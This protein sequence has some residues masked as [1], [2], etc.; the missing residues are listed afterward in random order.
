LNDCPDQLISD[1]TKQERETRA[2]LA[3]YAQA[4]KYLSGIGLN[5][6]ADDIIRLADR[7]SPGVGVPCESSSSGPSTE[8]GTTA[9]SPPPPDADARR[10]TTDG[11]GRHHD[12]GLADSHASDDWTEDEDAQAQNEMTSCNAASS[13]SSSHNPFATTAAAGGPGLWP[14]QDEVSGAL[15]VL[16]YGPIYVG[17]P[18]Q[19]F[20]VDFDTGSADLWLPADC[21]NC[22]GRQ[23]DA[24]RSS[25]YRPTNQ[26]ISI[27][28]VGH[29]HLLLNPER[30]LTYFPSLS[31]PFS[32]LY[33][34]SNDSGLKGTGKVSGKVVR[35]VVSTAGLTVA[36]QAFGSVTNKSDEFNKQPNDGLIGMAFGTIAQSRQPT[37]FENLIK[38]RKLAA[39]LFSVHLSR[40]EERGSSVRVLFCV[41]V[42]PG[43]PC[44]AFFERVL[45]LVPNRCASAASIPS[46]PPVPSSGSPWYRRCVTRLTS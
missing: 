16:Y 24:G 31:T 27:T 4:E 7:Y 9:S 43:H 37:F 15:D 28:Y 5:P 34:P 19:A 45:M 18:S 8:S 30:S 17:T 41:I 39:P 46:G 3:K 38:E 26:D 40:H 33:V 44:P 29:F 36:N 22:R 6:L 23:F 13:D 14:L 20:T 2:V 25:T 32:V 35:D 1:S 10:P 21:H 11:K 12:A 42:P